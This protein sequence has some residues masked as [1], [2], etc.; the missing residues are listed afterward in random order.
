MTTQEH[1]AILGAVV[2]LAERAV[3]GDI[4][5][6]QYRD[7][8]LSLI[9]DQ[10]EEP[11]TFAEED[12]LDR[13]VMPADLR[14]QQ[15]L[16]ATVAWDEEGQRWVVGDDLGDFDPDEEDEEGRGVGPVAFAEEDW[17]HEPGPRSQR[18]WVHKSGRVV[19][20]DT[21][22]GATPEG[23]S[24]ET[25][26]RRQETAARGRETIARARKEQLD[27]RKSWIAASASKP[28]STEIPT[29][30][31][32]AVLA[33]DG[34][35]LA[36]EGTGLGPDDVHKLVGAQNGTSVMVRRGE[37]YDGSG[38]VLHL[39]VHHPALAHCTRT[40]VL[41]GHTGTLRCNNDMFFLHKGLEGGGFGMA[42]FSA[43]VQA[44]VEIG[45]DSIETCAGKGHGMNGYYTWARFGYDTELSDHF[46]S[47]IRG[48]AVKF[49]AGKGI[50]PQ[51]AE[52]KAQALAGAKTVQDLMASEDGREFWKAK[53]YMTSMS[54]DLTPGSKSVQV[55]NAYL[56]GKGK[57]AIKGDLEKV[58]KLR[59][60]RKTRALALQKE[61]TEQK[62]RAEAEARARFPEIV[63]RSEE[64]A[65]RAQLPH[66]DIVARATIREQDMP[67]EMDPAQRR[68]RALQ[69]GYIDALVDRHRR[70]MNSPRHSD[71]EAQW[72]E[73]GAHQGISPSDLHERAL[74][75][76]SVQTDEVAAFN[77]AYQLALNSILRQRQELQS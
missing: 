71:L 61:Q 63:Q 16:G 47:R 1:E 58:Q 15:L 60:D 51:E 25:H 70:I 42:Q 7:A 31:Q 67:A 4:T 48:R 49:F 8:V 17:K 55:L 75:Y 18:R 3:R 29:D 5:P 56:E 53:G 73:R 50:D 65:A 14:I 36:L 52:Q 21:N 44:L 23:V 28:A 40:L 37:T 62:A 11:S 32:I 10:Q 45:A 22:P 39:G 2:L 6:E 19:Y 46:R 38:T 59:E 41:S 12:R 9:E 64:R 54:F 20:S 76:P 43:Q 34:V 33:R 72:W 68:D 66:D 57:P 27:R 24:P 35:A 13:A 69:V 77:A 30:P 26:Q 74:R